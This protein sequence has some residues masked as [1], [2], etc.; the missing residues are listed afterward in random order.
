[1][2]VTR[3][4][5]LAMPFV[6]ECVGAPLPLRYPCG[7]RDWRVC[8]NTVSVTTFPTTMANARL[9][10]NTTARVRLSSPQ[11]QSVQS[12]ACDCPSSSQGGVGAVR[13][14]LSAKPSSAFVPQ[15][16]LR[17]ARRAIIPH[18]LTWRRTLLTGGQAAVCVFGLKEEEGLYLG[19]HVKSKM[20][21]L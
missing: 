16:M 15:G 2:A 20:M 17:L 1:M 14:A 21:A 8:M 5:D 13:L 10:M 12:G 11:Q 7:V 6:S 19:N 9:T 3:R 4:F 18:T